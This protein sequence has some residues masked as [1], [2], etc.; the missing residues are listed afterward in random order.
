MPDN[1]D[2]RKLVLG[3]VSE[4]ARES[5]SHTSVQQ[6]QIRRTGKIGLTVAEIEPATDFYCHALGFEP[7]SD[8]RF[9]LQVGDRNPQSQFHCN[10]QVRIVTLCLGDE[11][12]DLMHYPDLTSQP[13]PTDSQS[14]DLWFQH[15]AI[16]V[17]DMNLAYAHLQ[18][19]AF[20]PISSG[21]QRFPAENKA[22][23]HIRAFK[24]KDRDRH[25]LEVIEFPP[26]KG[27]EKWHRQ[28]DRLFLGIDHSAIAVAQTESSLKFYRDLWGL[29]VAGSSFNDQ[30][31]QSLL[32]HLPN[33]KV[34]VTTLEAD[35]GGIGIELL[36]Y[37]E[38]SSGRPF[39]PD[40]TPHD[41]AHMHVELWV[42]DLEEAKH[43]LQ[44]QDLAWTAFELR[45]SQ[46]S[47]ESYGGIWVKDPNGHTM[48]IRAKA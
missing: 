1:L 44:Q 39:P 21:P 5:Q 26:D 38:P 8:Q 34:N 37:L 47:L 16:V 41:L 22:S 9:V 28:T 2:S 20:E 7:V 10:I 27:K 11:S 17:R 18:K 15:F 24:F 12:I 32:D 43:M 36:D 29:Q 42:K 35:Q 23:A 48:L 13:I 46:N 6:W 30:T 14:N 19:L 25:N 33:A 3:Q 31:V 40:W 4:N 45:S